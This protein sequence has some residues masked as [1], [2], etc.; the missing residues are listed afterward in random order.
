MHIRAF[1]HNLI[2]FGGGREL[3]RKNECFFC[4]ATDTWG[5]CY[6]DTKR[7]VPGHKDAAGQ[8]ETC[9]KC[10]DVIDRLCSAFYSKDAKVGKERKARLDIAETKW[11]IMMAVASDNANV[12]LR[13]RE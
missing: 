6:C 1:A 8:L 13:R 9:R 4:G 2:A 7:L 10:F 5:V 12:L 11:H 3:I